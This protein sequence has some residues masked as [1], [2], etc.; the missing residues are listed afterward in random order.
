MTYINILS[1][2]VCFLDCSTDSAIASD[3]RYLYIHN[4]YGLQKIGSGY[5][6][7]IKVGTPYFYSFS[8]HLLQ[9]LSFLYILSNVLLNLIENEYPILHINISFYGVHRNEDI[10]HGCFCLSN[11]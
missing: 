1:L 6:D 2:S 5:G 10:I 8:G 11:S 4:S 3:G 7:T 9:F